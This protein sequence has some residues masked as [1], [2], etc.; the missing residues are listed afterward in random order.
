MSENQKEIEAKAKEI[1]EAGASQKDFSLC[2]CSD[3]K[4]K[5]DRWQ[6]IWG[7]GGVGLGNEKHK[8]NVIMVRKI[9]IK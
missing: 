8:H 5:I 7:G 4:D 1:L 2:V 3:G 6:I 9:K